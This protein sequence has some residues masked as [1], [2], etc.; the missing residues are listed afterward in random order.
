MPEVL[1]GLG[2]FAAS[3]IVGPANAS[4][5]AVSG[6]PFVQAW[7]ATMAMPP[8]TPWD[9][10]LVVP[11]NLPVSNGDLLN[12]KFWMRCETL[13]ANGGCNT[14]FIFER[15]ADPWEKSVVFS[16]SGSGEW[17]QKSE[18]F[19]LVNGYAAGDAHMVFRLGFADQVIDIGGLVVE[20]I[21]P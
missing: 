2:D 7:R 13:G 6:E 15:A 4:P 16:A 9:A 3:Y 20:K 12:V 17:T 18:F 14:E 8:A 21:A 11:L 1:V 5:F 19:Y 10:Q